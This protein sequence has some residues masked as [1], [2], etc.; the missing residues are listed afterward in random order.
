MNCEIAVRNPHCQV[1][2]VGDYGHPIVGILTIIIMVVVIL[3]RHRWSKWEA[4]PEMPLVERRR[5]YDCN[6]TQERVRLYK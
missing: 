3:K 6:R 5:C 1:H 4:R 2:E